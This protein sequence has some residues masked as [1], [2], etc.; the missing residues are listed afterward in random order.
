MV[1][2]TGGASDARSTSKAQP[3]YLPKERVSGI[4]GF[5]ATA[6]PIE[7]QDLLPGTYLRAK[8]AFVKYAARNSAA[9]T[10][11][12]EEQDLRK[13]RAKLLNLKMR[14]RLNAQQ[15]TRLDYVRWNLDQIE[16]TR[17]G[18]SLDTLEAAV[19]QYKA[20]L[21]EIGTL[22]PE[23]DKHARKGRKKSKP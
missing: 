2:G 9:S 5:S 19:Q 7:L 17:L 15:Q 3:A 11:R 22:R 16:N 8:T 18:P 23:F 14:D 12:T 1:N 13:E 6:G 10:S 21:S 4:D 20:L